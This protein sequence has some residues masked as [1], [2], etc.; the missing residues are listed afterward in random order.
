MRSLL[1]LLIVAGAT[2]GCSFD[3]AEVPSAL[4]AIDAVRAC[5]IPEV[6]TIPGHESE[7]YRCAELHADGGQGC[8]PDGYL[9]GYGARYAERFYQRARPRM[10]PRGRQWID[11]VLVCLQR[12]LR[13][14]ID[15]ST[16]CEEIRDIAFDSH[17]ICYVDAGFC[18]LPVLDVL[19]VVWT[20]DASD[21]FGTDAARQA[22]RTAIACGREH[23]DAMHAQFGYLIDESR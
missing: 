8:G 17:P 12:T 9:I 18:R 11:D 4:Q 22:V 13:E 14:S 23:A 10:S 19:H 2:S 5:P 7:F 20:I 3:E 15:A 16:S 6:D 1:V 21:W